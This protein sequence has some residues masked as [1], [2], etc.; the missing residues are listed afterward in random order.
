MSVIRCEESH[1]GR[2]STAGNGVTTY[3]RTFQIETDSPTD[4][5]ASIYASAV[6]PDPYSVHPSDSRCTLREYSIEPNDEARIIWSAICKYSNETQSK[7]EQ[8][9]QIQPTPTLR[10]AEITWEGVPREVAIFRDRVGTPI[11]NSAGD[12]FDPPIVAVVFDLVATVEVNLTEVPVWLFDYQGAVNDT[13]FTIDGLTAQTGCALMGPVRIS[14][15]QEENGI[16][17]RKVSMPLH[18]RAKRDDGDDDAPEPWKL[19][20]LNT[21]LR[22]KLGSGKR[23]NIYDDNVP[24]APITAPWPLTEAG[25]RLP[26]GFAVADLVYLTFDIHK[27]RDFNALPLT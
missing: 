22:Q 10:P 3:E 7:E 1:R 2:P 18:F 11:V 17:Y 20:I 5:A 4:D 14:P 24:P 16:V 8:E 19:E 12:P 27:R 25:L 26:E 23:V 21:G 13:S 15:K 9:R 6:L